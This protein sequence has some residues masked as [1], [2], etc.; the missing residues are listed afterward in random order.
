MSFR[1][2]CFKTKTEEPK[3]VFQSVENLT[4]LGICF[5]YFRWWFFRHSSVLK[6]E[7]ETQ[8]GQVFDVNEFLKLVDKYLDIQELD[9]AILNELVRKIVV[10]SSGKRKR[11][12]AG[13]DRFIL[14]LCR[15]NPNSFE[16]WKEFLK[17]IGTGVI[18]HTGFPPPKKNYLLPYETLTN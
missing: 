9:E 2:G 18:Q 13:T 14:Y 7:I 3:Q 10:H 12:K 1:D 16:D 4:F 6:R 11:K 5:L 15:A 17:R 8:D